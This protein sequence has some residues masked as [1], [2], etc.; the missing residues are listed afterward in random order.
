M[1]NVKQC[2][3]AKKDAN[4]NPIFG[5]MDIKYQ[6]YDVNGTVISGLDNFEWCL[7]AE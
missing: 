1:A 5:D 3:T 7:Y 4:N 2:V 6:L